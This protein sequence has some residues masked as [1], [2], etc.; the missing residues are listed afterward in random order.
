MSFDGLAQCWPRSVT[1]IGVCVAYRL[2]NVAEP[3]P[4]QHCAKPSD[5]DITLKDYVREW[6]WVFG[7]AKSIWNS[8]SKRARKPLLLLGLQAPCKFDDRINSPALYR[9]SYRGILRR[10]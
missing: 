2:F 3:T 5:V 8:D 7:S 4:G 9:L 1:S 10:C 6:G